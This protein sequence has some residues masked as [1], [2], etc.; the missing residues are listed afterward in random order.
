MTITKTTAQDGS[1]TL[2]MTGTDAKWL[3]A[4]QYQKTNGLSLTKGAIRA[5]LKKWERDDDLAWDDGV[6]G[7][8]GIQVGQKLVP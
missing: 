1:V 3:A 7:V 5:R 6:N 8:E 4:Y 2:S